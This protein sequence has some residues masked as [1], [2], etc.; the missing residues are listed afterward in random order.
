MA[1]SPFL[2]PAPPP[3]RVQFLET[4]FGLLDECELRYCVL[5]G[6]RDLPENLSGDLDLVIHPEDLRRLPSLFRALAADGFRPVQCLEYNV[7]GRTFVFAWTTDGRLET[8]PVDFITEHRRGG[9]R[10]ARADELLTGRRRLHQLRISAPEVEF[11]YLLAKKAF[12]GSISASQTERLRALSFDIGLQASA[13]IIRE[14]FGS[15]LVTRAIDAIRDGRIRGILPLLRR[16]LLIL[17]L[18]QHPFEAVQCAFEESLRLFGRIRR[19]TGLSV[20]V[21]GPDGVGKST[22]IENLRSQTEGLFR[23]QRVFHWRPM[24]LWNRRS[25]GVVTDPHRLPPRSRSVSILRLLIYALDYV[26]GHALVVRPMLIR[27]GV[28]IFDR[29]YDDMTVDPKRFR[30][31]AK[32]GLVRRLRPLIPKPCLSF[33]LDAPLAVLRERKQEVTAAETE[34]QRAAFR[35]LAGKTNSAFLCDASGDPAAA[36]S[37]ATRYVL[38]ELDRRFQTRYPE[39]TTLPESPARSL[40][41]HDGMSARSNLDR[42]FDILAEKG[43]PARAGS[44]TRS[45][46]PHERPLRG[47]SRRRANQTFL[48]LPS[49]RAPR[50][51]LP[52]DNLALTRSAF[53]YRRSYAVKARF[54]KFLVDRAGGTHIAARLGPKITLFPEHFEP[55]RDFTADILGIDPAGFSVILGTPGKFA[56]VGIAIFDGAGNNRAFLKLALTGESEE[57]ISR[58]AAALRRLHR[59]PALR[60]HIPEVLHAGR[61]HGTSVLLQ[62]AVGASMGPSRFGPAHEVFEH[63]LAS[64]HRASRPGSVLVD[65]ISQRWRTAAETLD[66][67]WLPDARIA[68]DRAGDELASGSLPCGISHGDFAPWNTRI[69][70]DELKVFDWEHIR[71]DT[72]LGWDRF[73]FEIQSRAHL[74]YM[75]LRR[76]RRPNETTKPLFA[77]YLVETLCGGAL[78]GMPDYER[79]YRH[80]CLRRL[81]G[82]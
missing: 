53:E 59:F 65:E 27:S 55:L 19:P 5:H 71:W 60:S 6:H 10:L 14:L 41:S 34:R 82:R 32:L 28:V 77:L 79:R 33:V 25:A 4:L 21:L 80:S 16:R 64:L 50:W 30:F 45:F 42:A 15:P 76:W 54:A 72:P 68:L 37:Q 63:K 62:T 12:K 69:T 13:R 17:G 1:V 56:K 24:L 47:Q 46:G 66:A 44:V 49:P 75:R 3:K 58:E 23:R 9:R 11:R 18:V 70:D 67:T 43:A 26:V 78:D 31:P 36:A 2:V 48:V 29:Y 38:A 57:R 40:S 7:H 8:I 81:I 74:P 20:A 61:W 51:L 52:L 35:A 39:W 22:L 73:H